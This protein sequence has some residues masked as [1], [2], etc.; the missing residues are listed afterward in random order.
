MSSTSDDL[1]A[2]LGD[3]TFFSSLSNK[4]LKQ[5]TQSGREVDHAEG[6]DVLSAGGSPLGFHY[7]LTGTAIVSSHGK[8]VRSLAPGDYFGEISLIDGKPRSATV[9]AGPGLRTFSVED[10]KPFM[11][12]SGV[13]EQ[14]LLGLCALVRKHVAE[15]SAT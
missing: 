9:T 6:K 13:M 8:S 11:K 5:L 14:L 1:A 12:E 3:V 10:F 4:Q 15:D 7:V 2:R